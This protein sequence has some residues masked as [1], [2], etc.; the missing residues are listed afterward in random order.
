MILRGIE[1]MP[2]W[3]KS[4]MI[5][6]GLWALLCAITLF[7]NIW[8]PIFI[9][10][11]TFVATL[12]WTPLGILSGMENPLNAMVDNSE[13][14]DSSMIIWFGF[15]ALTALFLVVSSIWKWK[16]GTKTPMRLLIHLFVFV[17]GVISLAL[18]GSINF[19]FVL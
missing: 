2:P 5:H 9:V 16:S 10:F 13:I 8:M 6:I 17:I 12:L 19:P 4:Y 18:V 14:A 15:L 3:K 11:F 1:A 7:I